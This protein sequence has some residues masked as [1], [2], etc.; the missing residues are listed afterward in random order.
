MKPGTVV[1]IYTD[2]ITEKNIEGIARLK[3]KIESCGWWEGRRIERWVVVFNGEDMEV[4]RN[5]LSIT[6][7]KKASSPAAALTILLILALLPGCRGCNPFEPDV[8]PTP[9]AQPTMA[10][11]VASTLTP[12]NTSTAIPTAT[13]TATITPIPTPVATVALIPTDGYHAVRFYAAS[14]QAFNNATYTIGGTA[15][16]IAS[17]YTF[18]QTTSF[19]RT[20]AAIDLKLVFVRDYIKLPIQPGGEPAGTNIS[21]VEIYI[22]NVLAASGYGDSAATQAYILY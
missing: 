21:L 19:T 18:T 17:G 16:T 1:T 14:N 9:T 15:Q 10:P 22:D 20:G 7:D 2:P 13:A 4:E 8:D 11:I 12:A 6:V 3:R 5:I